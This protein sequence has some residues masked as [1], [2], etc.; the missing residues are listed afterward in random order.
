MTLQDR[1]PGCPCTCAASLDA[2]TPPATESSFPIVRDGFGLDGS[3]IKLITG[4]VAQ[5]VQSLV[6][7]LVAR[8]LIVKREKRKE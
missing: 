5:F 2:S 3:A 6:R 1:P 8:V 4:S 7:H